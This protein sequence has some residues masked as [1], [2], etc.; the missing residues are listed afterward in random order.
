MK[1]GG[2]QLQVEVASYSLY[3]ITQAV[4]LGFTQAKPLQGL[5]ALKSSV[6]AKVALQSVLPAEWML[7]RSVLNLDFYRVLAQGKPGVKTAL[8]LER[9]RTSTS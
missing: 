9:L 5:L 3:S 6:N 2:W 7:S 1:Y 4:N 8:S